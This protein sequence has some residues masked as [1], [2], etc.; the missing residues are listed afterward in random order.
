VTLVGT[1]WPEPH[2]IAAYDAAVAEYLERLEPEPCIRSVY[3]IGSVGTPGISDIDLLLFLDDQVPVREPRRF[4]VRSL[5]PTAQYLF[6]HDTFVLPASAAQRLHWH[7]RVEQL[8]L[9][10]GEA[11]QLGSV[12]RERVRDE[13]PANLAVLTDFTLSILRHLVTALVTGRI[14]VRPMLCLL[15]SLSHSGS[16]YRGLA[17]PRLAAMDSYDDAVRELREQAFDL[18]RPVLLERCNQAI[19]DGADLLFRMAEHLGQAL[20]RPAAL[21]PVAPGA[22]TPYLRFGGGTY[23][24]FRSTFRGSEALAWSLRASVDTSRRLSPSRLRNRVVFELPAAFYGQLAAYAVAGGRLSRGLGA[25]LE[26]AADTASVPERSAYVDLLRERAAL[27]DTQAVFLEERGIEGGLL[28]LNNV[29]VNAAPRS[30]AER[31][32]ERVRLAGVR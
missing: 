23:V 13:A 16:V 6:M 4:S 11:L 32:R 10:R 1:H 27:G 21:G 26:P 30:L 3:R 22:P 9:I 12:D 31:A 7:Y 17:L 8:E 29:A 15:R 25:S 19:R 18:P 2:D 14:A 28:F 20:Q 24:L 5:S